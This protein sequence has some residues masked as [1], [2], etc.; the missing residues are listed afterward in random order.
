M[1]NSSSS[2]LVCAHDFQ[3]QQQFLLAN[4]LGAELGGFTELQKR[5]YG[6][7]TLHRSRHSSLKD[8][9]VLACINKT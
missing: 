2:H 7:P 9:K 1:P 3:L 6:A 8:V 5:A 4:G